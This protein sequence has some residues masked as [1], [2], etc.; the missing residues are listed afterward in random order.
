VTPTEVFLL[1][2]FEKIAKKAGVRQ[3]GSEIT[4]S[5]TI[6]TFASYVRDGPYYIEEEKHVYPDHL[7]PFCT[8]NRPYIGMK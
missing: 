2:C 1:N 4:N 3:S 5:F 7:S 8:R 6:L